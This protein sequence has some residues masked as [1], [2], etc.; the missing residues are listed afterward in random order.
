MVTVKS[1]LGQHKNP[2]KS[3]N[4]KKENTCIVYESNHSEL[5]S[6][7]KILNKIKSWID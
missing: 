3:L 4:F 2:A 5:L 1:A 7:L 6:N